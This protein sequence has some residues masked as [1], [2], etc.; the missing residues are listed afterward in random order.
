MHVTCCCALQALDLMNSSS[1]CEYRW[2]GEAGGTLEDVR[3]TEMLMVAPRYTRASQVLNISLITSLTHNY[4]S[5]FN[6][7]AFDCKWQVPSGWCYLF[8][9][10]VLTESVTYVQP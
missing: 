7:A 9:V 6:P 3:C 2:V 1:R 10:I 5:D 8:M 4:T